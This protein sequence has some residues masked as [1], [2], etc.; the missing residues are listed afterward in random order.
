MKYQLPVSWLSLPLNVASPKL[1][2]ELSLSVDS[3]ISGPVPY[4]L[5]E[6][7]PCFR[8]EVNEVDI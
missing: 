2:L 1:G 5:V 8:G 4:P 6:E 7:A 3:P